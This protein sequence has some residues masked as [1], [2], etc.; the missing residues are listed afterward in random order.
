M[1]FDWRA[2]SGPVL[3]DQRQVDW[4]FP[5]RCC[6]TADACWATH[7]ERAV[8]HTDDPD[9]AEYCRSLHGARRM[10]AAE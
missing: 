10:H 3:A 6:P 8:P 7:G 9:D 1:K 5:A 2:I 4:A